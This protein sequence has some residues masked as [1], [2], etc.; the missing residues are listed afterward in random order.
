VDSPIHWPGVPGVHCAKALITGDRVEGTW[1]RRETEPGLRLRHRRHGESAGNSNSLNLQ[2]PRPPST[3][4]YWGAL[5]SPALRPILWP[6][7]AFGGP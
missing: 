2:P 7:R 1:R 6:G 5:Y 3:L 4:P